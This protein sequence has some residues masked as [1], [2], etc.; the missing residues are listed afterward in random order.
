MKRTFFIIASVTALLVILCHATA[1]SADVKEEK[2][3]RRLNVAKPEKKFLPAGF[4]MKAAV[5]SGYD[6]NPNLT[7]LKK[8]DV[9]EEFLF[10]LGSDLI[11][12]RAIPEP[13]KSINN[14]KTIFFHINNMQPF[15]TF[16]P[17]KSKKML[18]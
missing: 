6:S 12:K 4:T 15:Y 11:T 3:E 9:F 14:D 5:S 18:Q 7:L 1:F 13:A 17:K 16:T 8:G 10:N 2:E